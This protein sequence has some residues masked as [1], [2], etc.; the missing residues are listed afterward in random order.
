MGQGDLGGGVSVKW[1]SGG[2]SSASFTGSLVSCELPC[3]RVVC[4]RCSLTSAQW[5]KVYGLCL[6]VSSYLWMQTG[7]NLRDTEAIAAS[8]LFFLLTSLPSGA[9]LLLFICLQD[10][11][12]GKFDRFFVTFLQ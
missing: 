7:G 10:W 3:D 1:S 9:L 8:L 12:E 6:T 2:F 4:P 11:E 5:A